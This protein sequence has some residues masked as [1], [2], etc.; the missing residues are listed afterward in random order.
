MIHIIR[1]GLI[2]LI[3]FGTGLRVL[4]AELFDTHQNVRALGM[5]NAYVSVV[6]DSESLFYNPAG[7]AKVTGY[8]W[9]I[10]DLRI[11]LSGLDTV[12]KL[13]NLQSNSGFA[14]AINE[15]YGENMFLAA[16]GQTA[17]T[18]PFV[19]ASL[20]MDGN[21]NISAENPA[22]PV[23][24]LNYVL[25]T[26]VA[27]GFGFHL[28]PFFQMGF[29]LKSFN[30]NGVRKGYGLSELGELDPAV[31]EGDLNNGGSAIALDLGM[32][33]AIDSIISPTLSFVWRNVG[34]TSIV[35]N[36][37]TTEAP[38]SDPEEMIVGASVVLDTPIVS[39]TPSFDFRYLNRADVQLA[40]KINF[41]IEFDFP[42]VALRGGYSQGYYSAGATL[43]LGLLSID[44]ATWG[45]ELG[46]APG[47]LEDR[48]YMLQVT[49]ELGF[50]L[51]FGGSGSGKGGSRGGSRGPRG[52]K[53]RR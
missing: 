1:I 45:V 53:K 15:L 31:F 14:S 11:G 8:Y 47:Q 41:G 36:S 9:K 26:G 44:A 49:L 3:T 5:G 10:F 33:I 38:P 35:P 24:N 19:T 16:G 34:V 17:I 32:N 52:L 13:S 6:N 25:D 20:Y 29:V 4:G 27:A 43:G 23:M 22:S 7:L 37:T 46:E 39:M 42:F 48:R 21:V 30:R 40:K 28:L 18:T 2:L 50:D 51:G 12:E